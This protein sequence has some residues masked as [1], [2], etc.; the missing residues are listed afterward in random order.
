MLIFLYIPGTLNNTAILF[1]NIASIG[2]VGLASF[3][4]WFAL[5]FTGKK[6]ILESKI[7]YFI[8]FI[9]PLILIYKKWT[10]FLTIDYIE[11]SWGWAGIWSNTIWPKIFYFYY[12][13]FTGT[14]L[15]FIYTFGRQTQESYKKK[16]A[17]IIYLTALIS[18]LLSTLIEVLLPEL[19]IVKYPSMANIITLIWAGGL[20]YAMVKYK[21]MTVSPGIIAENILSTMADCLVLLDNKGKIVAINEALQKLT[22]YKEQEIKGKTVELFFVEKE[23]CSDLFDRSFKR[24]S[25]L[26]Q[27]L[28]IKTKN[29]D[30]VPVLLSSSTITN[31]SGDLLGVVYIFR[32]ITDRKR[33]EEK[34]RKSQEEATSMFQNSP[35]AGI[36]HDGNGIILDVNYRFTKL[37]GYSPEEIVGRN[38]NEGM[39]FP[40][41][42][43]IDESK[44]LTQLTLEGK[45]IECETIRKKKDGTLVPVIITVAPILNQKENQTVIAFYQ[46]RTKYQ[47]A[48]EKITESEKK[49]HTL[50]DNMPAAYYRTD[51]NG[52]LLMMN[53]TGVKLLGYSS[54]S[55]ASG[56]NMA[57][58]FYHNPEN[59]KTFLKLLKENKGSI[60]GYEVTLKTKDEK[61][62]IVSTNSQ[63][64][65]SEAGYIAGVEGIF[66]DIT[67]RKKTE[68]ALKKS[69]EEFAS[70]FVSSPEALVYVDENSSILDI[71]PRF[72]DLFGYT[73]EEV[74]GKNIN[75][76]L[77]HPEEKKKEAEYLYKKS[78]VSDYYN[79]ETIR[80][81]K[82]GSTIPVGISSSTVI[83]DGKPKGRIIS[84]S[85]IT[86]SKHNELIQQILYTIS[87]TA[88]STV[89]INLLYKIIHKELGKLINTDN[90]YIAM[91]DKEKEEIY[92]PYSVDELKKV[93]HP[94]KIDHQSLIAYIFETGEPVYV[95]QKNI[96]ENQILG[97]YKKWFGKLRK[98]WIGI[99]LRIEEETIGALVVQSYANPDCFSPE[100]IQLLEFISS[101]ISI[102]IKRKLDEE[103]LRKSQ[104]EFFSLFQSHSEALLY[105]NE[106]GPIIDANK[107]FT[108]LFGYTLEEIKGKNVNCGIIHPKDR[109]E[110]GEKLDKKAISDGYVRF[111][112]IRKKKD[113]TLFPVS[114][115]GSPV[116]IDGENK[117][118]IGTFI[119]ITERKKLEEQLS[120]MARIDSLTGCYNR[121]HGLEL[122]DR[123]IRL[124]NRN[125][126]P[127]LLAFFDIDNFKNINDRYGHLEGDTVLKQ[128]TDLFKQNLREVDIVCRMG[129]DEF[130]LVFPDTP[131]QESHS[132][133]E[134][135]Q[136][137]LLQ[138]NREINKE[139]NIQFSMGFS[140]Y[141]PVKP[142][143]LDE[144]IAIAD[145][146]MYE[147]KRKN[148]KN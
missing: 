89:S 15:Y 103:A 87:K 42:Q 121:R 69:R 130:L 18:L 146:E 74:R 58:D 148:K 1:D 60:K 47:Q 68:E 118:I 83:I 31:E 136:N 133:R 54:L 113:G 88:N 123:Q 25:V 53:P 111:E 73:K 46:D 16:Q 120:K 114:I 142:R 3:F 75:N 63:Y 36:Y 100:D 143:G 56:K 81:R 32:D 61:P 9:V 33:T 109:I 12:L 84:Y 23:L 108:Q 119:D 64:Y 45:D 115:S 122:I 29:S 17:Q 124:S 93:H 147:E 13:S 26:N 22:G 7:F 57:K 49:Y 99:P 11:Q 138:L 70:L 129:G 50:F 125:R 128:I 65:Y 66:I 141:S 145:Q 82:N 59:R 19:G 139:Y 41:E 24:E 117:G 135:L 62:L 30:N 4:L 144:L 77:I 116:I 98:T 137:A 86:I 131:F 112:T 101:Q 91:L 90:F 6:E 8:I 80:K 43:T 55:E 106:K 94:R 48:L 107:R 126:L 27:E 52:N 5:I 79:Y 71:N 37:F 140:E 10:G 97:K 14:G 134:R 51:K 34:L 127:L 21:F 95:N 132:I 78:L 105:V 38:I 44:Y 20:V 2:W 67:E 96:C 85:D 102:A 110:E 72:T 39:I 76:G 35:L 104:Q 92:F 40:A 28:Y